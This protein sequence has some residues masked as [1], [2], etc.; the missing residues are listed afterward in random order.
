MKKNFE[1]ILGLVSKNLSHL[2]ESEIKE[3]TSQIKKSKR[4]FIVGAGRSGL[5]GRAFGM[6]LMHLGFEVFIVGDTINPSIKKEDLLL[7]ISGSGET[8]FVVSCVKAAKRNKAGV[9][10][11]CGNRKSSLGQVSDFFVKIPTNIQRKEF[12]EKDYTTRQLLGEDAKNYAPL[13]TLFELSTMVF[14]DGVISF[15]IKDGKVS[16]EEMKKRH[17]NLE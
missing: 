5:V 16:E 8:S 1:K 2:N 7:A 9:L 10:S 11:I 13:G 3:L 14:L 15:L 4:I 17:T 12:K 6:R